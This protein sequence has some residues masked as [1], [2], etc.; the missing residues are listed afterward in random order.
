[1][2]KEKTKA[3]EF[4]DIFFNM[5]LLSYIADGYTVSAEFLLCLGIFVNFFFYLRRMLYFSEL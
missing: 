2:G 4:M 5:V 3:M 1:M